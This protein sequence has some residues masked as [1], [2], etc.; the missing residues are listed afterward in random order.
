VVRAGRHLRRKRGVSALLPGLA[1]LIHVT[2]S[3]ASEAGRPCCCQAEHFTETEI[4][5]LCLVA[6]GLS[7]SEIAQ[8]MNISS[9]TVDRHVTQM[10][11]R[12]GARNR[13]GLVSLAFRLG[14]LIT[15]EYALRPSGRRCLM[16]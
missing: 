8:S 9:H 14:V 5:V 13:A 3:E 15:D 16:T 1:T 12:S 2:E 10:L 4:K 7:N 11:R 6:D